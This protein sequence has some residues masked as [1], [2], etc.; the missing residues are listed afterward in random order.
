METNISQA[1]RDRCFTIYV[2]NRAFINAIR[3]EMSYF[4]AAYTDTLSDKLSLENMGLKNIGFENANFDKEI[5]LIEL[6]KFQYSIPERVLE[7]Y[8]WTK[9]NVR[10]CV[11]M[12]LEG[13][14]AKQIEKEIENLEIK[15][16]EQDGDEM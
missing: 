1:F 5:A 12:N 11:F 14:Y 13:K 2:C 3:D 4:D 15:E 9:S 7:H 16:N 8:G 6:D 10:H